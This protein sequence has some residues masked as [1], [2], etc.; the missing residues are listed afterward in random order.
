MKYL[1]ID[2]EDWAD[3]KIMF[4]AHAIVKLSFSINSFSLF[5]VF[6]NVKY[7]SAVKELVSQN[8]WF[9]INSVF[10]FHSPSNPFS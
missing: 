3:K 8:L 10:L 6:K 5:T 1:L 9:I 7:N 4:I 2:K